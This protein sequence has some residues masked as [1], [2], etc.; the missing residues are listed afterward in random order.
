VTSEDAAQDDADRTA[1]EGAPRPDAA[2]VDERERGVTEVFVSI[3][4]SLVDGYDIVD[5]YSGLTADCARLLAVASAGLLLADAKGVLHAVAAS[6]ERTRDLEWFQLQAAEGPCVDC[7]RSGEVV[8]VPDLAAART[9]WPR[10]TE[11]ATQAGFASVHAVP[12]RLHGTVLGSLNLFGTEIGPVNDAD[13]ALAQAFAHVASVAL[14]TGRAAA[15]K[16]A[17]AE[18]L[19]TALD[20]RVVLEQAKGIL[21]QLGDVDMGDA[22]AA[23]RGYARDHNMKLS[24]VATAV[25]ARGLLAGVVLAHARA[26]GVLA[27]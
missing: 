9:R 11:V 12:M 26:K 21:S 2:A 4:D 14:V 17:L 18:Q 1:G 15:D 27:K 5:L 23:L 10:F 16:T 3:A 24:E 20:S 6:C 19:Q 8:L 7:H 25:A 22:F 13:L